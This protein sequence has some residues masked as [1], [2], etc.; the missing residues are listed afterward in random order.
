[1][2]AEIAGRV[3]EALALVRLEGM[4]DRAVDKLSGGQQQRVALARALIMRPR[5]LLL[6]EPLAA[7]DLKLR[8]AMQEELRRIHQQIGGPFIFAPHDGGGAYTRGSRIVVMTAGR[9][10]QVGQPDEVYLNP[11]SL[12]VAGFVG[13]MNILRGQRSGNRLQLAAGPAF[14]APG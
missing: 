14:P 8:Q 6:D 11:A 2:P 10:E 3:A 5:V 4:A 12:F 1:S 7:L 13:E 9:I